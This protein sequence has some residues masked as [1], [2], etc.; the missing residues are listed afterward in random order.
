[1]IVYC[2]GVLKPTLGVY[3]VDLEYISDSRAQCI[4]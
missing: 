3:N 2:E 1:M 4:T